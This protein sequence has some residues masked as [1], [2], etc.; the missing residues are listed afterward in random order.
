MRLVTF[1]DRLRLLRESENL[2]QKELGNI[3]NIPSQNISKYELNKR[4]PDFD[5]LKRIATHFNVS[6]DFL[7][8]H[9]PTNSTKNQI[10]YEYVNLLIKRNK[11]LFDSIIRASDKQLQALYDIWAFIKKYID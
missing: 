11:D 9:N 8:D 3:L 6:I 2:S 7:L 4:Q 5:T 1:G 10:D